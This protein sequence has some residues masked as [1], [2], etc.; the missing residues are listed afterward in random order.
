M[1]RQIKAGVN[2]EKRSRLKQS[3]KNL[4]EQLPAPLHRSMELPQ[5]KGAS[6]WPG[7]HEVHLC[8]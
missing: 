8:G 6:T 1:Q 4:Q 3:A 2:T 5:E 7:A